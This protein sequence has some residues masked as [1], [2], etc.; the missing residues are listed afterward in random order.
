MIGAMVGGTALSATGRIMQGREQAR[1]AEFERQQ[2]D[3]QAQQYKTAADQMEARR[4]EELTAS[5]ETI[6][7]IRAGRGVGAGSPTAL[8]VIDDAVSDTQ[9]DILAERTNMRTRIDLTQRASEMAR[10]KARTSLIAGY[11]GAGEQVFN[12]VARAG[13]TGKYGT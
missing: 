10:R 4:R 13:S 7:A 1:A 6:G 3:V 2:L 11:V 8:A 5:L 12:T 9:R